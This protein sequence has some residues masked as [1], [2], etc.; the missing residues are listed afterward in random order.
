[1]RP[2]EIAEV[3]TIGLLAL[4]AWIISYGLAGWVR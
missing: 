1:M 2:G 4:M 3:L